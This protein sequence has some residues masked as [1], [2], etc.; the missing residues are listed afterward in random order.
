[1]RMNER[2]KNGLVKYIKDRL[3]EGAK[4]TICGGDG[5]DGVHYHL[6]VGGGAWGE[7]EIY[8]SF[9]NHGYIDKPEDYAPYEESISVRV[10]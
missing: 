2:T 7:G 8:L 5:G 6:S 4:L 10:Y 9:T 3:N 1:M